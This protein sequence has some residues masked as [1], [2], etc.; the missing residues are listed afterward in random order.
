VFGIIYDQRLN[1]IAVVAWAIMF[2]LLVYYAWV[3][4]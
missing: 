1:T 2:L 3:R 4:R